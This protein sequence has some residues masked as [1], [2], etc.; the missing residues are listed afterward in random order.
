MESLRLACSTPVSVAIILILLT[1]CGRKPS[2]F[3]PGDVE[4]VDA[5]MAD[6]GNRQHAA[7][8]SSSDARRIDALLG[9]L[10]KGEPAADHKCVDGGHITLHEKG[11]GELKIGIL[12]GH[13]ARYYE[14]RVYRGKG[15]GYDMFRVEREPFLKAM[16]GLGLDVLNPG[17]PK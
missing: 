16:T 11:G 13:D 17:G 14:F 7:K 8:T 1:G 12:T 9:V 10:R 6:G 2:A 3:E 5:R 4:T 15:E